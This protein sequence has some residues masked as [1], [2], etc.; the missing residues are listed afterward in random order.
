MSPTGPP[1]LRVRFGLGIL[2]G[3]LLALGGGWALLRGAR[4]QLDD[5]WITRRAI[6]SAN[7][8]GALVGQAADDAARKRVAGWQ[9]T[10]PPGTRVRAGLD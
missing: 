4:T 7:S 5:D 8:L 6:V 10:H 9:E 2:L 1:A 3:L